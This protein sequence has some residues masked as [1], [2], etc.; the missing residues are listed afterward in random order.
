MPTLKKVA[1]LI[2]RLRTPGGVVV[3]RRGLPI[4]DEWGSFSPGVEQLIPI[5]VCVVHNL[6]GRDLTQEFDANYIRE[7]IQVYTRERIYVAD[8][9]NRDADIILYTGRRYKVVRVMDYYLQGG[10]YISIASL[11]DAPS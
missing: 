4:Q 1:G 3:A 8:G 9:D 6:S 11:E 5:R 7:T 10:V 2:P